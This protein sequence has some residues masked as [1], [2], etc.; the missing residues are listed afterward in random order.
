MQLSWPR[1]HF[2]YSKKGLKIQTSFASRHV[3]GIQCFFPE[4]WIENSIFLMVIDT[5]TTT[6]TLQRLYF[7]RADW[8]SSYLV[9]WHANSTVFSFYPKRGL[10]IQD[11]LPADTSTAFH[12]FLKS[13]LKIQ[14]L[15]CHSTLTV[16]S[17]VQRADW[18]SSYTSLFFALRYCGQVLFS[19]ERINFLPL[20][21]FR[22][23]L[24]HFYL[25]SGLKI[26]LRCDIW[27]VE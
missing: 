4:E 15:F 17:F 7:R 3:Y 5:T 2:F 19:T 22:R 12:V 25:K 18:K 13:E 10:K 24:F 21:M 20:D 14:L 1:Q 6:T 26:Q 8:T 23:H 9:I 16:F 11:L 27:H